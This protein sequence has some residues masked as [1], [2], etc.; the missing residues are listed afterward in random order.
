MIKFGFK[1]IKKI[2]SP[3]IPPSFF[4]LQIFWS[5]VLY[6][7]DIVHLYHITAHTSYI[8]IV[9]MLKWREWEIYV[10]YNRRNLKRKETLNTCVL[11]ENSMLKLT[12][13][14]LKERSRRI[15]DLSRRSEEKIRRVKLYE[16][17]TRFFLICYVHIFQSD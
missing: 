11:C 13:I 1:S 8:F 4:F 6:F 3:A 16:L 7:L 9:L 12:H 2:L 14:Q 10:L 5:I 15:Y 17:W